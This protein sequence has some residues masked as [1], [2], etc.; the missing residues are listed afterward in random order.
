MVK[1]KVMVLVMAMG[2]TVAMGMVVP[3]V[4]VVAITNRVLMAWV[5]LYVVEVLAIFGDNGRRKL[6]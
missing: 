1:V 2:I 3:V 4:M 5:A 6:L